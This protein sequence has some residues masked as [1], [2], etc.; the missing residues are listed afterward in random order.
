MNAVPRM[1]PFLGGEGRIRS[2]VRCLFPQWQNDRAVSWSLDILRE[3]LSK[4]SF[5]GYVSVSSNFPGQEIL[6]DS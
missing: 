3:G 5:S 2:H 4:V 1:E 6:P